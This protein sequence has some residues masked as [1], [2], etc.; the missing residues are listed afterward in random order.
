VFLA[1]DIASVHA[2]PGVGGEHV[3]VGFSWVAHLLILLAI[4]SYLL[5]KVVKVYETM[6]QRLLMAASCLPLTMLRSTCMRSNNFGY[7]GNEDKHLE[8]A[9]V[10]VSGNR[11][12]IGVSQELE[13]FRQSNRK[14]RPANPIM[15]MTNWTLCGLCL[16]VYSRS[17]Y[18]I[19]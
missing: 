9:N 1:L 3:A 12:P 8:D 17:K 10:R 6:P 7:G 4:C 14:F 2:H 5:M 16:H 11:E 15:A 19:R 18:S 13:E